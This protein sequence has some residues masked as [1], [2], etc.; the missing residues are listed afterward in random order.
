MSPV[1]EILK[2]IP[3]HSGERSGE[4]L[5]LNPEYLRQS[6]A[7]ISE[8]LQKGFDV[9][10]LESGD[11]V[12]TGTK[13]VVTQYHWDTEKGRMMKLSAKERKENENEGEERPRKSRK[14]TASAPSPSGTAPRRG[15]P[16]KK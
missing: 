11:I 13:V 6:S 3:K 12:T 16:K 15:R 4:D 5:M 8:A 2:H 14:E 10:Q 7:V 1:K 9:L